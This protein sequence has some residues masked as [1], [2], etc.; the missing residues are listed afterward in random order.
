M[1]RKRPR[2]NESQSTPPDDDS[3]KALA[4]RDAAPPAPASPALPREAVL[5]FLAGP[6]KGKTVR[7]ERIITTLGRDETCD[8]VLADDTVSR[9]HGQIEQALNQWV[10]TNF[11]ENG[12]WINRQK[13]ERAVLADGDVIEV[14]RKTRMKFLLR[15]V[16]VAQSLQP[17]RRPRRTQ[18]ELDALSEAEEAPTATPTLGETLKK[19]RRQFV[20][21]GIYL[22]VVIVIFGALAVSKMRKAEEVAAGR[23]WYSKSQ[24]RD[25]IDQ[26]SFG[27]PRDE[28]Q[29]KPFVRLAANQ[30]NSYRSGNEADLYRCI[31]TYVKAQE[32]GGI[33]ALLAYENGTYW[34][35]FEEAK[36]ELL[37]KVWEYYTE[38]MRFLDERKD[39]AEARRYYRKIQS[40]LPE[41]APIRRDIEVRLKGGK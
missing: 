2:D 33:S 39:L 5:E 11:S 26:L 4:R 7:L 35:Q 24:L 3:S 25:W 30:Y 16:Q 12:S 23:E 21:L 31:E 32:S 8:L 10:Y 18:A 13:A 1:F 40:I 29:F 9:E 38:C 22:A 14:G 41:D 28:S 37:K 27:L 6:E 20:M 36:G 19:R 17:R 15:E 34:K